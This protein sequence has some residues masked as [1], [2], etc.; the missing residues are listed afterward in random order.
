MNS[1]QSGPGYTGWYCLIRNGAHPWTWRAEEQNDG[2]REGGALPLTFVLEKILSRWRGGSS[3]AWNCHKIATTNTFVPT[4]QILSLPP[5][6]SERK[7]TWIWLLSAWV[8]T[9]CTEIPHRL[10]QMC[11]IAQHDA[12][13]CVAA[14]QKSPQ[15]VFYTLMFL[16]VWL[17]LHLFSLR[18]LFLTTNKLKSKTLIRSQIVIVIYLSQAG[19]RSL[20]TLITRFYLIL[21]DLRERANLRERVVEC[22]RQFDPVTDMKPEV[23]LGN[24]MKTWPWWHK[25]TVLQLS[26][27]NRKW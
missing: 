13:L 6:L 21:I 24:G 1:M 8:L 20:W 22:C 17:Y 11:L 26:I 14:S 16:S 23:G 19:V 10:E 7:R 4:D 27:Q 12:L 18:H 25:V 5:A 3:G 9:T 2:W 15:H